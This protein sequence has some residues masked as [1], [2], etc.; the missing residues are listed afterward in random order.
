MTLAGEHRE[1]REFGEFREFVEVTEPGKSAHC[2]RQTFRMPNTSRL[3]LQITIAGLLVETIYLRT[4]GW[5]TPDFDE[6]P[7]L[8]ELS[9]L[10][11]LSK[12]PELS[13]LTEG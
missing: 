12:L 9:K 3:A 11:G 7:E 8:S 1:F 13:K 6:L 10:P 5:R 2:S 4:F